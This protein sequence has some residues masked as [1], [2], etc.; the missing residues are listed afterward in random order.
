MTKNAETTAP[1]AEKAKNVQVS[2]SLPKDVFEALDEYRWT[3][4]VSNM[5]G[6]LRLAVDEFIEKH[7]LTGK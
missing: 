4:R 2:T 7:G 5:S 6:M 1:A 3:K